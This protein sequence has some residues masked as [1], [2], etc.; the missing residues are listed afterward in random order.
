MKNTLESR[1]GMFLAVAFLAAVIII[2][3]IGGRDFF[4]PGYH[5]RAQFANIHELKVGDPVKMAGVPVG[6]VARLTLGTNDNRVDV[7]LRLN[8]NTPVRTDSKAT[9]KSAGLG[10]T[11]YVSLDFGSPGAPIMEQNG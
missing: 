1:L 9:I 10:G 7:L 6:R 8:K 3:I 5:I 11:D 4:R 2:E